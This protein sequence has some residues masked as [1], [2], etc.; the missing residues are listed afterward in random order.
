MIYDNLIIGAGIYGL[1]SAL[2]LASRNK[3]VAIIETDS[4]I[5]SRASFVNQARVHNG[6]HYPRSLSTAIK[7]ANYFNRFCKDFNYAINKKFNKIYAIS[8]EFSYTSA[9]QFQT[10]CKNANINCKEV[11]LNNLLNPDFVESSFEVEEYAFDADLIKNNYL[12]KIKKNPNITIFYNSFPIKVNKNES[13]FN[14]VLN[15]G[16]KI[17]TP[18][19]I[20]STYASTNQVAKLF[21]FNS[22]KIK[23]E[24][25]E[26]ILC[27]VSKNMKKIGLTVIDG[28]F[29]SLMP[30]GK[31]NYHSLTSVTFTPHKTS[32][33]SL[34]TFDCQT[35]ATKCTPSHLQN[36]NTCINR[37]KTAW[38]YMK[39]LSKKYLLNTEIKYLKSY[40]AIKPI[41]KQSE[42]DD[43]RPTIIKEFSKNPQ[44]ISILSGKINTIYDLDDILKQL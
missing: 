28:P 33:N 16:L 23:Y 1:H 31:T 17:A 12:K 44:F 22:F 9:E 21:G 41:L 15:T 37:P 2:I 27:D 40:F 8:R 6:Y 35:P 11:Y 14:I 29:F 7:T 38:P 25:C 26:V 39:Q 36:C 18:S 43:S 34:P 42:L 32:Y 24:I 30:F 10:F 19:V 4:S 5:F 20:N 3:K 13:H